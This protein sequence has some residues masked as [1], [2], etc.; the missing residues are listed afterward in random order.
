[1]QILHWKQVDQRF[2]DSVIFSDESTFHVSS[3]VN[4]HNCNIWGSNNPRVSLE[5]VRYIPRVNVFCAF[6]K[7]RVQG[8]FFFMQTTIT[9]I[10]Y[11]DM[12]QQFLIPQ[13][14]EDYQ[15]GRIH[16]QQNG[17]ALITLEK[18]ASTSTPISQVGG[19]V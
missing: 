3:E 18:C 19:V 17:L 2:V 14:V 10:L 16:L 8:P 4:I 7:E 5:H 9:D 15:E 6:S 13:L 1:M 12:L 11:L